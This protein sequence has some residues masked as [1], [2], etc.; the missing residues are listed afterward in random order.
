MIALW[1]VV[2]GRLAWGVASWMDVTL[3]CCMIVSAGVQRILT[4]VIAKRL[5]FDERMEKLD[6][7]YAETIAAFGEKF[8]KQIAEIQNKVTTLSLAAGLKRPGQAA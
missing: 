2:V 1:A 7:E 3:S 8:S 6:K 4:Q 5:D